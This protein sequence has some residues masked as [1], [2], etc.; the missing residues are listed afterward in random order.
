MQA[1]GGS[2][3]GSSSSPSSPASSSSS[4]S[5]HFL[6]VGDEGQLAFTM[7]VVGDIDEYLWR[8]FQ[9]SVWYCWFY[10]DYYAVY[11]SSSD[12][13]CCFSPAGPTGR[14]SLT[15]QLIRFFFP[16]VIH[17]GSVKYRRCS[18]ISH[19]FGQRSPWNTG[20]TVAVWCS[21]V[22]VHLKSL[23]VVVG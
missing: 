10:Y 8:E 3:S 17:E 2:G 5:C 9:G 14:S 18:A 1:D 7:S 11:C 4:S 23:F 21:A 20:A 16:E 15:S 19:V 22:L 6:C 12:P 13:G